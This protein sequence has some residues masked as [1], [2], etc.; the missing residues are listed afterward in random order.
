MQFTSPYSFEVKA[1]AKP[2]PNAVRNKNYEY[3]LGVGPILRAVIPA[4]G[5]ES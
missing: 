4:E 5:S 2:V 3:A 1:E